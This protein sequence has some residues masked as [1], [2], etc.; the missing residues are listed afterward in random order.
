MSSEI[1][2]NPMSAPEEGGIITPTSEPT[3]PLGVGNFEDEIASDPLAGADMGRQLNMGTLLIVVVVLVSV[4]GLFAMRNFSELTVGIGSDKTDG[5]IEEILNRP[6]LGEGLRGGNV[7]VEVIS[8][9]KVYEDLRLDW[10]EV[11]KNPFILES[12]LVEAGGEPGTTGGPDPVDQTER[13]REEKLNMLQ[14]AGQQIQLQ[15]VLMGA[16]PL[17]NINGRI[18]RVGETVTTTPH[19][20]VFEVIHIETDM[21]R[22]VTEDETFEI[23]YEVEIEVQRN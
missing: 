23:V 6:Q 2:N 7:A 15:M 11:Q 19:D 5:K 13:L 18:V 3:M 22:L 16:R 14:A 10:E 17:A 21:V 1:Q 20:I 12:D 9:D 8:A 4:V